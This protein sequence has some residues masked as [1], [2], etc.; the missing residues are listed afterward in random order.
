MTKQ[1]LIKILDKVEDDA[2]VVV[3]KDGGDIIEIKE[4]LFGKA[5]PGWLKQDEVYL[6]IVD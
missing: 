4:V 5:A 6:R 1:E 3:N 2:R